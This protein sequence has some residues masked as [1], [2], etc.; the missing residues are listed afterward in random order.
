MHFTWK[1]IR[2]NQSKEVHCSDDSDDGGPNVVILLADDLGWGD[3]YSSGH[4]TSRTPNIDRLMSS[5]VHM[6]SLYTASPVCSPS[7]AALL[8]GGKKKLI[9]NIKSIV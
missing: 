4:P 2:Q 6:T 3:L 1:L 8:T 7:R 5:S 9:Q